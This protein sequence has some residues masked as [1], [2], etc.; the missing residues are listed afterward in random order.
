M[1]QPAHATTDQRQ[2]K[3][4]SEA[5]AYLNTTTRTAHVITKLSVILNSS[6]VTTLCSLTQLR[7][8]VF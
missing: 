3:E 7:L 6:N 8:C 2:Y 1:F 5:A 4:T